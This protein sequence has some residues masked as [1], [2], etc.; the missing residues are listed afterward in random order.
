MNKKRIILI[1]LIFFLLITLSGLV[2]WYLF[3]YRCNLGITNFESLD[4][5]ITSKTCKEKKYSAKGIIYDIDEKEDEITFDLNAFDEKNN[6]SIYIENISLPESAKTVLK[7]IMS[8]SE[9]LP[10]D[11]SIEFTRD[12][13][14]SDYNLKSFTISKLEI[15]KEDLA[16]IL[17]KMYPVINKNDKFEFNVEEDR[18][19][20]TELSASK[21]V[22]TN[23]GKWYVSSLG[24]GREALYKP[25]VELKLLSS[26]LKDNIL[27]NYSTSSIM[28][29]LEKVSKL[30]SEYLDKDKTE[31]EKN[32]TIK[33]F[34]FGCM[35]A[36]ELISLNLLEQQSKDIILD[37]YCN[38]EKLKDII[39]S[40]TKN[41]Y[42]YSYD[43]DDLLGSIIQS[44]ITIKEDEDNLSELSISLIKDAQSAEKIYGENLITENDIEKIKSSL[45]TTLITADNL[46]LN[47]V[48]KIAYV[49]E[50]GSEIYERVKSLFEED[51]KKGLEL[52][53][54]DVYS[55]VWCLGAFKD[56][57]NFK[58]FYNSILTKFYYLD[59]RENQNIYG[60]WNNNLYLLE[61]NSKFFNLLLDKYE[62]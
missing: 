28:E 18:K 23:D 42:S 15:S 46:T 5:F 10:V 57:I 35:L 24:Y 26:N 50:Q 44:R 19:Q 13:L 39:S 51:F 61:E 33:M 49:S 22:L 16:N 41:N 45:S 30:K 21:I 8:D 20:F 14:L 29:Y 62:N 4:R 1:I 55:T 52:A 38:L 36:E 7:E 3:Y 58:D 59:L 47:N 56:D 9:L 54:K 17:E 12:N 43:F 60:F 48:C 53:D 40:Y 11:I 27:Q 25:L 31:E 37:E 32:S 6:E 2:L 34:P